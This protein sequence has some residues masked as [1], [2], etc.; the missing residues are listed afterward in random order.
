[1]PPHLTWTEITDP[2]H[3][4]LLSLLVALVPILFIFWALII[5]RIKGYLASLLAIAFALAI[6]ILFYRMPVSLAL[7]SAANGAMFGL[8]PFCWIILPALFLFN[9]AVRSGQFTII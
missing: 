6:A 9:V 7:L 2:F 5:R 4:R 3:N 1:M 8:F